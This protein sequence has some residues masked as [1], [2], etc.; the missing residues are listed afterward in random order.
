[1]LELLRLFLH[2]LPSSVFL[3]LK[4]FQN[5]LRKVDISFSGNRK[6]VTIESRS[7]SIVWH[8]P[9]ARL[10]FYSNGLINR[11]RSIGKSYLLNLIDFRENDLIIDCGANTGDLQLFF[12]DKDI[13]IRYIGVEPN[14]LDFECLKSNLIGNAKCFNF[15]LW[16]NDTNLRFYV[17]AKSSSSSFIQ[18]PIYS[19]IIDVAAKRLDGFKFESLIKLLKIEGEGA[20]PEILEG[21]LGI[22]HKVKFISVDVGPER[23]V[24]EESTKDPVLAFLETHGF[25][26]VLENPFHRKTMLFKNSNLF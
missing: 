25:E 10:P 3:S 12:L 15:G 9:F 18:P 13:P 24:L 14:P 6:I 19:K 4:N 20:E 8:A 26:L 1:M 21:C 22:F 5:Y 23:G 2:K 7:K 11:G 17:D 16:N